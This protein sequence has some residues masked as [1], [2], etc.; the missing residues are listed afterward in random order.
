MAGLI[1]LQD[2]FGDVLFGVAMPKK[3]TASALQT[4]GFSF[5]MAESHSRTRVCIKSMPGGLLIDAA[6]IISADRCQP[7]Q[8]NPQR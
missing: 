1:H 4:G 3:G 5:S 2:F 6:R 7:G 8:R